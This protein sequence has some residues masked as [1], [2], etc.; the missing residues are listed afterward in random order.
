MRDHLVQLGRYNRWANDRILTVCSD[1]GEA[2][3]RTDTGGFFNSLHGTLNHTLAAEQIWL[4]RWVGDPPP[5]ET[6]DIILHEDWRHLAAA[7]RHQDETLIALVDSQ[8]DQ[9]LAEM[10]AYRNMAGIPLEM[11]KGLALLHLFNHGT[12][13]RGQCHHMISVL[14]GEPPVLDLPFSI[15]GL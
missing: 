6:L 9:D 1:L 3:C 8:T 10:L 7:R 2:A 12:H 15:L 11:Q 14:G 13:H 5:F 4:A